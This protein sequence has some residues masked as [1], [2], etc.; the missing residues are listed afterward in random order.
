MAKA[1]IGSFCDEHAPKPF[2]GAK[3]RWRAERPGNWESLRKKALRRDRRVCRLCGK[4]GS[5]E[6][7][8]I[9]P[10][11]EGGS[12]E[13]SNLQTLCKSCHK[14]KTQ[15]DAQRARQARRALLKK[16]VRR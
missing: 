5:N 12:W 14:T 16:R 15:E 4:V 11:A 9:T 3:E 13:L 7:D 10:V 2:E 8:H 1:T 6:V